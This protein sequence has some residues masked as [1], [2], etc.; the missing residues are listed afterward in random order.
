M[1]LRGCLPQSVYL[2]LAAIAVC[3][4]GCSRSHEL[5]TAEVRGTVTLDGKPLEAGEVA[6]I[7]PRGRAATGLITTEGT[8]VV[9]TYHAGDGAIVGP[10]TVTVYPRYPR[11]ELDNV[12]AN[13]HMVPRPFSGISVTIEADKENVIDI[14][15]KSSR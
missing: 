2:P 11:H 14:P 9:G 12:P 13:A 3:L 5:E 10:H 15:L 7:P 8:Y 1:S 6:F 4:A